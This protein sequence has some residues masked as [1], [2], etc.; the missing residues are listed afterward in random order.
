MVSMKSA[1][2]LRHL[3]ER[4][5][6]Y[7]EPGDLEA[8]KAWRAKSTWA[9]R[10]FGYLQALTILRHCI[11]RIVLVF[12]FFFNCRRSIGLPV[13]LVLLRILGTVAA[14]PERRKFGVCMPRAACQVYF[15]MSTH[16]WRSKTVS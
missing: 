5:D 12:F 13:F 1:I 8:S 15:L 7:V 11:S 6:P 14:S 16:L 9:Q 10:M 4:K 3:C 2:S